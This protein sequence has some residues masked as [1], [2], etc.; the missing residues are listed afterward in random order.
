MK[1]PFK[2]DRKPNPAI[3]AILVSFLLLAPMLSGSHWSFAAEQI[4]LKRVRVI[5]GLDPN[6]PAHQLFTKGLQDVFGRSSDKFKIEYS[7]EYLDL[8]LGRADENYRN[9][10]AGFLKRKYLLKPK[11]DLIIAHL[12]PANTFL[13]KYSEEIMPGVPVVF[14]GDQPGMIPLKDIP[15]NFAGIVREG[16]PA[17]AVS[18]ILQAQ[19][20]TKKIYIVIGDSPQEKETRLSF[21]KDL[22]M[23]ADKVEMVYLNHLPFPQMIEM[24]KGI[25][26]PSVILYISF[27]QDVNR[28]NFIPAKV[29]GIIS[30]AANVPTYGI[31]APYMGQ[32]VVGGYQFSA[33][34]VG[35][36]AAELG[37]KILLGSRISDFPREQSAATAEYR[38]DWR[39][40]KRWGIDERRLPRESKFEYRTP[41]LWETYKWH[42]IGGLILVLVETFLLLVLLANIK[43]RKK[44]EETL[45][46]SEEKYRTLFENAGEAIFVARDGRV[47]FANPM[48]VTITG[49]SGEEIASRP[50]VD[51][52]HPD[53]RDLIID[54]HT[55]RLNGEEIPRSYAFRVLCKNGCLLWVQLDTILINWQGKPAT[56]NFMT[57]ITE[58][59]RAEEKARENDT[60]LRIAGDKAKLGGWSVNLEEN[61]V[62]WSDQVA[63]IHEMPAGFSPTVE[64]GINFYAPEWKERITSVFTACAQKGIPYDEKMEIVTA[65][66][67]RVWVKA[68]GEAVKD[69]TGKIVKVQGA[70]QDISDSKRIEEALRERESFLQKIFDILPVG[71]WF[72]DKSGKLLR[73]N[74]AG[75]KIWGAE[76]HV[77]PSEYGVFRARRLPSGKEIAPEDWAL[78]HTIQ[79]GMTIV[80]EMLEIDAF[81]GKKKVILNYTAPVMDDHGEIQGAIVV[82]QEITER[83]QAEEAVQDAYNRLNEIIDF[84]PDATFVIDRDGKV[85]AWNRAM[86]QMS[87]IPKVEMIGKGDHEYAL[88]FYGQRRPML[89]DLALVP[90]DVFEKAHYENIFRESD[91]LHAETYVPGVHGGK[92]AFVWGVAS[93]LRDASGNI[94]G[95]IESSR[96]ITDR[97][98][99]LDRIRK[100]LGGTVQAIV[101]VVE[102]KDP[103]TAGHQRRVADISRAIATEIGLSEDRIEGIRMAGMIHDIGKISVPSE[104][105][106]KARKLTDAEFSLIKTHAQSG[107]DILNNIEF[108]WPIARIVLEHHE[109][110]NGSGYPNGLSGDQML[111]ESRIMAVADVV[112]AMATHRPYRPALGLGKALEEITLKRGLLYD[113]E[114]VDACLRLF[115]DKGYEIKG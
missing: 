5:Y 78:V 114:V 40:L 44:G 93:R 72:A 19:P 99:S 100:A 37:T 105:L 61:R 94:I 69:Q 71:L 9:L 20:D 76:P 79:K 74:P 107:Y 47:V 48:T 115:R 26:G 102:S 106:S 46:E 7:F 33:G 41:T 16:N 88:P 86:E 42:I 45:R 90:D 35:E 14:T 89:I 51:F 29:A 66:G 101:S 17:P 1:D 8:G 109:R 25:R 13:V 73:G 58:R 39:A 65:G 97:K 12:T 64:E 95:A 34:V 92:G 59:K 11:P 43:K 98:S 91:N 81:D 110:M 6:F 62:I 52:I 36:K 87:G 80:D 113:P 22:T 4:P 18:L 84:L 63:A 15:S 38:F 60:L 55:R 50:F 49:Y 30:Q 32:G 21:P 54:R 28:Q 10:L 53:D 112:E 70:F 83:K 24:I 57:D 2:P 56:L 23:F 3:L 75:V 27:F 68:I 108:P 85:I 31:S 82:N 104:I 67:K 103:Y 77:A 111:P 96:D